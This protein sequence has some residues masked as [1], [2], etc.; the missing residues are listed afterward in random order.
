MNKR[1]KSLIIT[2]IIISSVN[3]R[4]K[5]DPQIENGQSNRIQIF[6]ES[7]QGQSLEE[8]KQQLEREIELLDSQ[9]EDL[10]QKIN[11]DNKNIEQIQL[12][13]KNSEEQLTQ[14]EKE[15]EEENVLFSKR[16]RTMYMTG[17][18]S[19]LEA[20]LSAKGI[21]DFA[22]K[23]EAIKSIMDNDKKILASLNN[24]KLEI[25]NKQTVLSE[26]N[27][28][29]LNLKADNEEKLKSLNDSKNAQKLLLDQIKTEQ[30][31]SQ[32]KVEI[33]FNVDDIL[34]QIDSNQ[35]EMEGLSSERKDIL[36]FAVKHM[37]IPYHWGGTSPEIGFDCSGFT[38]YV[39][40]N[41]GVRLGRTTYDQLNNGIQV[42]KS[43]L[44]PGDLVLFGYSGS[45]HHVGIY[46]GNNCYIHSPRTGDVIRIAPLD[47]TDFLI[48]VKVL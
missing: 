15:L 45:P 38:Q 42:S 39:F 17:K 31:S 5:A 27:E 9:I 41:F 44:K 14:L 20:L 4:I 12:E 25:K 2:V 11:I 43:E 22:S 32:A 13:I 7:T 34:K 1:L 40:G 19:Y 37:G 46:I 33:Q 18:D 30:Q 35:N 36:K 24:K 28:K 23:V 10:I 6:N 16:V 3:V 48:G 8:K 47:R 29:L 26:K 21:S